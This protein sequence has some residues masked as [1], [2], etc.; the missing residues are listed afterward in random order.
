MAA[1]TPALGCAVRTLP[2]NPTAA[3]PILFRDSCSACTENSS[4]PLCRPPAPCPTS[5]SESSSAP[6]ATSTATT[7]AF[8]TLR[9]AGAPPAIY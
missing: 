6:G 7:C 8:A 2:M 9:A 1:P 3:L 5:P 4:R